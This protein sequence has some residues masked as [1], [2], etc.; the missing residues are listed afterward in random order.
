V[1]SGHSLAHLL[2]EQRRKKRRPRGGELANATKDHEGRSVPGGLPLHEGSYKWS[3]EN[4]SRFFDTTVVAVH[5]D[6]GVTGYGEICPLGRP[7]CPRMP[8]AHARACGTRASSHRPRS[9]SLLVVN[10]RMDAALRGHPYVKSALDVACWDILA[11]SPDSRSSHCWAAAMGSRSPCTG[12]FPKRLPRDGAES[13]AVSRRGLHRVQL[14]AGGDPDTDI[15]RIHKVASH[16][17][18][19][20]VLVADANTGWTQHQAIRSRMQFGMWTCTSNS[21]VPVIRS[22]WRCGVTRTG[23]SS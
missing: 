1:R 17:Q 21:R 2:E 13:D 6:M 23:R 16:L 10:D 20:D 7:T 14:K 9:D 15:K 18:K 4:Q 12:R 8:R 3:G 22:V 19:G 5:T 11:R